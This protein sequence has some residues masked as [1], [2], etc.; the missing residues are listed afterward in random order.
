M[1]DQFVKFPRIE[2]I[3]FFEKA[4]K[5]HSNVRGLQCISNSYYEID[6]CDM[7]KIRVFVSN[8]YALGAADYYDIINEYTIDCLITISNWNSVTEE[9][10]ELGKRNRIGVFTMCEFLGALNNER[11]YTYIRP[12]D[13]EDNN[14]NRAKFGRIS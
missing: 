6:R 3:D 2:S 10:Y 1:P 7:P 11:P 8:Y 4:V 5:G 12:V 13:R 9:A 14:R